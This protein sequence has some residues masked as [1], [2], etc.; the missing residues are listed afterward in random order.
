MAF[1]HG[2]RHAKLNMEYERTKVHMFFKNSRL[3]ACLNLLKTGQTKCYD[4][5]IASSWNLLCVYLGCD[6][7]L[8][9]GKID[10]MNTVL[11]ER[12]L[13]VLIHKIGQAV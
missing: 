3:R 13:A 2:R 1:F 12:P 8:R 9:R 7:V 4:S 6:F 5:A 11:F 10:D